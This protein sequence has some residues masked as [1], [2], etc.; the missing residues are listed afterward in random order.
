[1]PSADS[2]DKNASIRA[3]AQAAAAAAAARAT[4]A[5][6]AAARLAAAEAA[7]RQAAQAAMRA[8]DANL[9]ATL[10]SPNRAITALR[11]DDAKVIA[12]TS[13][14][15]VISAIRADDARADASAAAAAAAAAKAAQEIDPAIRRLME[16]RGIPIPPGAGGSS[17]ANTPTGEST[18]D[19]GKTGGGE[20]GSGGNGSSG[21]SGN[22]SSAIKI[23]TSNLFVFDET[24]MSIDSM[25]DLIFEEIGGRELI[26]ITSNDLVYDLTSQ[27]AA[28]Q[29]IKNLSAILERYNPKSLISL[30]GSSDVYFSDNFA[31]EISNYI[32]LVSTKATT[33]DPNASHVYVEI[34][35][36]NNLDH[37]VIETVNIDLENN[38]RVEVQILAYDSLHNGTIY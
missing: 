24:A 20:T 11:E 1:M 8:E 34:D 32:P 2:I 33:L 15:R 17:G 21:N 18:P 12:S 5:K 10:A 19:D 37:L 3:Q 6:A 27:A 16:A 4:A 36:T 38:E 31:M 9:A 35:D 28:N 7:K 29:P 13:P 14:N 26:D 22:A 23:A 30:Q 25:A